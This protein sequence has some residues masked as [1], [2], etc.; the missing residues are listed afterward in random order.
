MHSVDL[1]HTI[2]QIAVAL[3]GFSAIIVALN[4]KPIREWELMDQ[5]NIRLLIQLS[6]VVIFFS[7][8][9]SLLAISIPISDAWLYS[10]WGYG[11]VH[12]ADAGFFLV[13]KSKRAPTVFR[14]VAS[15]G[16]IV[17]LLQIA[18]ALLGSDTARETMYVFTLI[19]HLGVI[20][21]AFILLLYQVR[22]H[23][24]EPDNDEEP[25]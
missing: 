20:F 21:M 22:D 25:K 13:L 7:L 10:L 2:A 24:S 16:V 18:I 6:I 4:Q 15:C 14:V 3:A 23:E 17:G 5:V 11:L 1:M 9:P 12:I 8:V 19:W